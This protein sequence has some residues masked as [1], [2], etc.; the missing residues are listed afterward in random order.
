MLNDR[1]GA[2]FDP[3][4]LESVAV[5]DPEEDGCPTHCNQ[6][7]PSGAVCPAWG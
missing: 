5:W 4:A 2:D 3:A 6:Y 1:F 7:A